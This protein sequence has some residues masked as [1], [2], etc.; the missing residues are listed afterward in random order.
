[1]EYWIKGTQL[2]LSLSLLIVLH[3]F[4]HY[5]PARI[6]KTRIEK[7]YLFF[8]WKFSLFKKKIGETEWGI[9]WIPLGGFVKISGMI[10][11]SMDKEQMAK[12]PQ[13]WEFR[14]KPAWQRLIIMIGGIAVNL[15][16]GMII[17]IFIIFGYGEDRASAK[18]LELGMAIHPF[19]EQYGI[20]SGDNI[21]EIDDKEVIHY[22]DISRGLIVRNQ[23]K[24]KVQHQD[25]LIETI[26]LPE[27][28]NYKLFESGTYSVVGLR[29]KSVE[30]AGLAVIKDTDN[31][32]FIAT[33]FILEI[34]TKS[35]S[36]IDF[37]SV[38][39]CNK[40]H[41]VKI[42]RGKD[43]MMID[44]NKKDFISLLKAAPALAAGLKK[45][46]KILAVND[47]E[48][49][50]FDEIVSELYETSEKNAKF[51]VL[52]EGKEIIIPVYVHSMGNVGFAP[53][54]V[55]SSDTAAFKTI[56]YGFGES[57]SKGINRAYTTLSDYAG[58][59]KYLFTE[60]GATSIGGFGSMA[61]LFSSTWQWKS[62]WE[63]TAFISIVLAFMN[64]LPIPALD[65]GHVMFLLYEIISGKK[66]PEKVMEIGQYI[67]FFLLI[68]LLLYA[69]GNDIYSLIF[70]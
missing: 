30:V 68:G 19:L 45:K 14:S 62:F 55:L 10:D 35:I 12:P 13:P 41:N 65:G 38:E 31:K 70:R 15:V 27:D 34:D 28:I 53:K 56:E 6:F 23:T 51:T 18:D 20:Y 66:A 58:Q 37:S 49:V 40:G 60:R 33:D 2:I 8:P 21:L 67:G 52:R 26:K 24:L 46:D 17:Y 48:I 36:E 63:I 69:N 16:I 25:G 4:G 64:F 43:T 39:F 42:L 61:G 44:V 7:F 11:E 29:H 57:V 22:A 5:I 32:L 54:R 3:E 50:Y 59:L 9:G 1:M 47:R